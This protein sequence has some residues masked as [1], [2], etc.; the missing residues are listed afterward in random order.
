MLTVYHVNYYYDTARSTL[1]DNLLLS[2][3][4]INY[5]PCL[6]NVHHFKYLYFQFCSA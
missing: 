4:L 2:Q 5:L 1:Q 3:L 6:K